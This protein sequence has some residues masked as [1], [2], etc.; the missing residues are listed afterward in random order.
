MRTY[1]L[2]EDDRFIE[3]QQ[4]PFGKENVEGLL[5][6]W[7][8]KNPH[9]L[10]EGEQVLYIGRQV[11]TKLGKAIDLLAVNN[12]GDVLVIELKK[13]RTPRD[14]VAQALE[15][16]ASIEPLR[17][18]ELNEVAME[19]FERVLQKRITLEEAYRETYNQQDAAVSWNS[20]QRIFIVAQQISPEIANVASYLRRKNIDIQ[21]IQFNYFK[22]ESGE[23]LI[24]TQ[25]IVGSEPR[26]VDL[27]STVRKP[28]IN[29][30]VLLERCR[31]GGHQKA[32]ELYIKAKALRERRMEVGDFINWGVSGYSYRMRLVWEGH[33]SDEVIFVGYGDGGLSLWLYIVKKS[34]GA[35]QLYLKKLRSIKA[36][37]NKVDR[38]NEP[39]FSTD[40][41]TAD[42]IDAFISAVSELASNL[43]T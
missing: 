2:T 34:G 9:T 28:K 26:P 5:E 18:E 3:Y 43:G 11:Q 14:V 7:L 1:K 41:M 27:P 35:G 22:T 32:E 20:E 38:G 31:L 6:D 8:E 39:Y 4:T 15:Y 30:A 21:A 24:T 42:E 16:T 12:M 19:Y 10:I 29:E 36:F 17:Y 37:S 33:P 23:R 13:D 40:T 25:V